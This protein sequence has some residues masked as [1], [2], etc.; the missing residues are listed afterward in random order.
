VLCGAVGGGMGRGGGTQC[1]RGPVLFI[2]SWRCGEVLGLASRG[3]TRRK[4]SEGGS[5][6][7]VLERGGPSDQQRRKSGG[8]GRRPYHTRQGRKAGHQHVGPVAT[9]LGLNLVNRVKTVQ[10]ELNSNL[11]PVQISFEPNKTFLSSKN[12]K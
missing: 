4:G 12:L 10:T 3:A 9:V 8:C 6:Q 1:R 7:R 2:G 11:K 5:W